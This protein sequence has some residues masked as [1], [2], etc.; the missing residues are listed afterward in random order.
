MVT[1]VGCFVRTKKQRIYLREYRDW[2][3]GQGGEKTIAH[4]SGRV[5]VVMKE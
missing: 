4:I 3:V 2:G 1:I 5:V